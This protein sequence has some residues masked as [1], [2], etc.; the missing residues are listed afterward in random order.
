MAPKKLFFPPPPPNT[1][2]IVKS[3]SFSIVNLII[4][5]KKRFWHLFSQRRFFV[6]IIDLL[7]NR[8]IKIDGYCHYAPYDGVYPAR[9]R[10][11]QAQLRRR[12][13]KMS[14]FKSFIAVIAGLTR[15]LRRASKRFAGRLRVKPAMTTPILLHFLYISYARGLI[16]CRDALY[17]R[18]YKKPK[19]QKDGCHRQSFLISYAIKASGWRLNTKRKRHHIGM[20]IVSDINSC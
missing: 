1:K 5:T 17:A 8:H 9:S 12:I 3:I 20:N 2:R 7:H 14:F 16:N 18:L 19:K 6:F 4:Q 13:Y 10:R 11:T 15:N